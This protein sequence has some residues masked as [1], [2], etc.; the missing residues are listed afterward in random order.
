MTLPL[1]PEM[2]EILQDCYE[3]EITGQEP[4]TY[5][6][7]DFEHELLVEGLVEIKSH[8]YKNFQRKTAY[9]ITEKGLESLKDMK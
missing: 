9:F 3:K 7:Q 4:G 2:Y 5:K 8:T 1:S 6:S